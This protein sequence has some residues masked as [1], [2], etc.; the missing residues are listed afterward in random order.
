MT[1]PVNENKAKMPPPPPIAPS[2]PRWQVANEDFKESMPDK[3]KFS[4]EDK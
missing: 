1:D 2:E 3:S 4:R